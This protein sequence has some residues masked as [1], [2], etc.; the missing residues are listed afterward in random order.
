MWSTSKQSLLKT[1]PD[2][3]ETQG[4]YPKSTPI[5]SNSALFEGTAIL[6]GVRNHSGCSRLH[7]FN[8]TM[9]R[10]N[11]CTTMYTQRLENPHNAL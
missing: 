5:P 9:H 10:K 3:C 1:R 8:P 4:L 6:S 11:E 2:N 7:S